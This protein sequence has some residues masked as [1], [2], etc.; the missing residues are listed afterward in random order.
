MTH[1]I[2]EQLGEIRIRRVLCLLTDTPAQA[3]SF[4]RRGLSVGAWGPLLVHRC[5]AKALI[6]NN[7][8]TVPP[9][10]SNPWLH[11]IKAP[12]VARRFSPWAGH[13][14]TPEETIWLGIWRSHLDQAEDPVYR[15]LGEAAVLWTMHYWLS[16]NDRELE[17]KPLIP[18]AAFRHY[19]ALV[20]SL[21]FDNHVENAALSDPFEEEARDLLSFYLPGNIRKPIFRLWEGWL[22]GDPEHVPEGWPGFEQAEDKSAVLEALSSFLERLE[23]FPN[24]AIAFNDLQVDREAL[25]RLVSGHRLILSQKEMAL[26]YPSASGSSI[27]KETFLIAA[28]GER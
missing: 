24:W 20:N 6:E 11:L 2:D 21:V 22:S 16:L 3:L 25:Y 28:R 17:Y 4:K 13:F 18:V 19:L 23:A 5:W 15:A 7:K 27:I 1:W 12:R 9:E 8:K 26:P 14:F 10:V